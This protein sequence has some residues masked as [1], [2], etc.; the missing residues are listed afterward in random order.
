M[1]TDK[2]SSEVKNDDAISQNRSLAQKLSPE[3]I[4]KLSTVR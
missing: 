3:D 1:Y 4:L 2:Q